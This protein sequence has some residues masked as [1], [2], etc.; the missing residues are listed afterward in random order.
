[1]EWSYY[2]FW[3][4]LEYVRKKTEQAHTPSDS[5]QYIVMFSYLMIILQNTHTNIQK[6]KQMSTAAV[7]YTESWQSVYSHRILG[8]KLKHNTIIANE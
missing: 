6:N 2:F 5:A 7:A 3:G 4:L 1:M 8:R